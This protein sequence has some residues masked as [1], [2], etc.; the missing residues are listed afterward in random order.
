VARSL[1]NDPPVI[2]ADEPT[3]NLDEKTGAE[4][5]QIF[6]DLKAQGRSVLMVT[7]NPDYR[8][9]VDRVI[10]LHDGVATDEALMAEG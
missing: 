3:G 1:A 8:A 4:V 9:V 2:L 10:S 6:H 7:H 5:L